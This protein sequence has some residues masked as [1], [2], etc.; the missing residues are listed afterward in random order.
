MRD[1][2]VTDDV[3]VNNDVGVT[4]ERPC[5]LLLTSFTGKACRRLSEVCQV[6][7]Q[8]IHLLLY[9]RPSEVDLVVVDEVSMVSP[10]L[11][12]RLLKRLPVDVRLV[13]VGDF[14]QLP[15]IGE[16]SLQRLLSDLQLPTVE[17]TE[18]L[19]SNH[20]IFDNC[21]QLRLHNDGEVV[22]QWTDQFV[23]RR[24]LTDQ[25]V[26]ELVADWS[27]HRDYHDFKVITPYR[28]A[29]ET[30]NSNFNEVLSSIGQCE[31]VVDCWGTRWLLGEKVM[32]TFNDADYSLSNGDEG[33]ITSIADEHI[34]VRFEPLVNDDDV[35]ERVYSLETTGDR[36]VGYYEGLKIASLNT[37]MIMKSSAITVHK[38]QGSEWSE[39]WF[40][41]PYWSSFI[42]R[43]LV[44]TALTRAR[45]RVVIYS[46]MTR[47]ELVSRLSCSD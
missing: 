45:D 40:Y 47:D 5:R 41:L 29:A 23:H 3:G 2:V 13:F 38:A 34:I 44:Y 22:F 24:L 7:A 43:R 10:S 27:T 32:F 12:L 21:Q 46:S 1:F 15:P 26:A 36:Y 16:P 20:V 11:L 31:S 17:L 19:R 4:N 14:A 8:T 35:I 9:K 37:S 39:V 18:C 42:T 30:L 33:V 28:E 25:P 6:P